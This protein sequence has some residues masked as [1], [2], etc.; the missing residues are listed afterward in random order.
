MSKGFS[1]TASYIAEKNGLINEAINDRVLSSLL[2]IKIEDNK[3][4]QKREELIK[5]IKLGDFEQE[6]NKLLYE[7]LKND[8]I[9]NLIRKIQNESG[10]FKLVPQND[11]SGSHFSVSDTILLK[12]DKINFEFSYKSTKSENISY[13]NISIKSLRISDKNPGKNLINDT[14]NTFKDDVINSFKVLDNYTNKYR[15][16]NKN[17]TIEDV[18]SEELN[19]QLKISLYEKFMSFF[20]E[21]L[22]NELQDTEKCNF[23][24]KKILSKSENLLIIVNSKNEVDFSLYNHKLYNDI[25]PISFEIIGKSSFI[26]HFS[27]ALSFKFRLHICDNKIKKSLKL[28]V[29]KI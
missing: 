22:F 6:Y 26:I 18:I 8:E 28:E 2:N 14:N 10:T 27:N 23:F 29:Y 21:K 9:I 1:R 20:P 17:N 5:E 25:K 13:K 12:N 16:L 11:N 3:T 15:H 4:H 7:Y 19:E 24:I